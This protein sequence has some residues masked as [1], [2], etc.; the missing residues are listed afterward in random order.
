M[1]LE[2]VTELIQ[3]DHT[4]GVGIQ[5]PFSV[6]EVFGRK[7]QLK[8]KGSIDGQPFQGSLAPYGGIHYMAV[9]KALREAVGKTPGEQVF[10]ML[11]EDTEVRTVTIPE[12]FQYALNEIPEAAEFFAGYSYSHQKEMVEWITDAKKAETRANR[13]E[14]AIAMILERKEKIR[15]G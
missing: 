11:E 10:V 7:G 6:Q 15:K 9:K 2:F 5:I 12:D 8:V 13:I 4:T 14:K 3:D 1:K